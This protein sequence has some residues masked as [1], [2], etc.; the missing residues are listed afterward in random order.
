MPG[1]KGEPALNANAIGAAS[2]QTAFMLR[3]FGVEFTNRKAL[4]AVARSIV[5]AY[6][7]ADRA[8]PRNPDRVA[9]ITKAIAALEPGQVQDFPEAAPQLFRNYME[10]A[11]KLIGDPDARWHVFKVKGTDRMRVR[12]LPEGERPKRSPLDSPA[13]V[14]LAS[15]PIG[16]EVTTNI[17]RTRQHLGANH[18]VM[19]RRLLNCPTAEWTARTT[20]KGIRVKRTR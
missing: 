11:R 13:A 14:F 7:K 8:Q 16:Q 4:D 10:T 17:F 12:R 9:P 6:I 1:V 18:K 15:V 20:T 19:A 3:Q 2:D 5:R